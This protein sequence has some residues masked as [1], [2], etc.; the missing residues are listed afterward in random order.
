MR[1]LLHVL[2]SQMSSQP[3]MVD[4]SRSRGAAALPGACLALARRSL[5]RCGSTC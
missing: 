4:C 1:S 5:M 3:L 2:I